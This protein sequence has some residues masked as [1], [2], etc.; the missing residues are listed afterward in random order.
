MPEVS[1]A[2]SLSRG[3]RLRM[4]TLRLARSDLPAA[5]QRRRLAWLLV[6]GVVLVGSVVAFLPAEGSR[7]MSWNV[8][9]NPKPA[10]STGLSRGFHFDR[11]G[12]GGRF[13]SYICYFQTRSNLYTFWLERDTDP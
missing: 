13:Q 2:G 6:I 3:D 1:G 9:R 7:H 5:P 8:R 10:A 12:G 4:R 11:M